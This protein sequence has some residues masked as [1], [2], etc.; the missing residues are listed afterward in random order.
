MAGLVP[1]V[2]LI[3]GAVFVPGAAAGQKSPGYHQVE[4]V[5]LGGPGRWDYFEVQQSTHRIFIPRGT[6]MMIL[7]PEGKLL[8]D[9][10]G[11]EGTHGIVFA[12]KL[13]R[14]FTTNGDAKSVTIFNTDTLKPIQTVN[15]VDR[16]PDGI[17]YDPA[18]QR[19]FTFND[20]PATDSTAIDART[21]KVLGKIQLPDKAETAQ[22]DGMGHVF[23][24][25]EDKAELTEF[26][27]RTLKVMHTWSLAPCKIPTGQSIDL[28][29]KRLFVGCRSGILAVV[30]Y[31]NGKVV[32]TWPIGKG[33]DATR[34]DPETKL[35]FASCGDG[36]ITVAHQDSADKYTTVQTITT[37]VG[38]RTMALD[39]GNHNI[40]TVTS[41]FGPP[42][43]ATKDEP[44]PRPTVI[45]STFRF[46]A[47]SR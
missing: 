29:H 5:T 38:A 45:S 2:L 12:P 10:K 3:C 42:P 11:L 43:P 27:S 15:L 31:T 1:S 9:I 32:A 44:H 36:T 24:N 39:E 22:A 30:N 13:K 26:N 21:G 34:Y 37:E 7:N 18:S 33:V 14:A 4:R 41:N 35:V 6:H 40:Y 19:V 46:L 47:Y 25:I 17:L 8:E 20:D 23:V 28:V 16:A